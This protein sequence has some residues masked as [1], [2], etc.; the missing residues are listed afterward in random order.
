MKKKTTLNVL[1]RGCVVFCIV[2]LSQIAS[3][4]VCPD[5]NQRVY[6]TSQNWSTSLLGSVSNPT[7]AIDG[8]PTTYSTINTG[9]VIAGLGTTYQQL[10]WG[11][12]DIAAGTPLSVKLGANSN[13][14]SVAATIS[15][16]ARRDGAN[17][18]SSQLVS[19]SLLN[20]IAGQSVYDFTFIPTAGGVPQSYDEVRITV[21][22]AVGVS[23]S[24][25][26]FEAYYHTTTLVA[27]CSL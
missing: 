9:I 4:Q 23:F 18:G 14:L 1:L 11:G 6:A 12:A 17:V 24:V 20:L 21:S 19:G 7:A 27:D 5:I 10:S 22:A 2:F 3:S 13:L 8:D 26:V 25:N 16:Q 15:V